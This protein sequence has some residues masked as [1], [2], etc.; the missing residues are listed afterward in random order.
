MS[1]PKVYFIDAPQVPG[2]SPQLR[3]VAD[4]AMAV[5]LFGAGW[6]DAVLDIEPTFFARFVLGAPMTLADAPRILQTRNDL[7]EKQAR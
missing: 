3:H 4:E 7:F 5:A 1:D 2:G 6:S